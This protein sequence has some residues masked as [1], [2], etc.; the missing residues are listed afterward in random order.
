[1]SFEHLPKFEQSANPEKSWKERLLKHKNLIA[2]VVVTS[3]LES[4]AISETQEKI[5]NNQD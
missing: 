1:M 5:H 2:G 4:E 3:M